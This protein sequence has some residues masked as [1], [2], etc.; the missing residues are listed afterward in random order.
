M[1]NKVIF[2]QYYD[3]DSF[4][5]KLDPRVKIIGLLALFI[6]LFFVDNIY[7]LLGV[8]GLLFI[9]ILCTKTPIYKF[10]KSIRAMSFIMLFTFLMQIF[11]DQSKP[12]LC[13]FDFKLTVLS[14][15]VIVVT[16]VLWVLF[17]RYIKMFKTT[18]LFIILILLFVMQYFVNITPLITPYTITISESGFTKGVFLVIRFVDF[19][20]LS[21]LLTL[22]TKPT[23]INNAIDKLLKPLQ[24]LGLNTGAFAM[25]VSVTLRFIP[26]LM[27]EASK[28]LKAQA[29]RGADLDEGNIISKVGQLIS[30]VFPLFIVTYKKSV[31]LT[32]AM[33][34]RGYVEKKERSSIYPLTYKVGDYI[35]YGMLFLIIGSMITLTIIF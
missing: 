31:D 1:K 23:Q 9:L 10:F 25:I 22:T 34:A 24:K 4:I 11:T 32:Y 29:S 20:F 14:L 35:A 15:C 17:S 27:N 18:I 7:V 3:A 5:H 16:L 26:T 13:T 6:S 12:T 30:L 21:S 28:I 8:T 33:E 19:L 2:G